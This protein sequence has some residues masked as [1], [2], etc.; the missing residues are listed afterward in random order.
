M[1]TTWLIIII[2]GTVIISTAQEAKT[3][4]TFQQKKFNTEV[5]TW[6]CPF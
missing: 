6:Y 5:I 2:L 1:I 4:K 3:D